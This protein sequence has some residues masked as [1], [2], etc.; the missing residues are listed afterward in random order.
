MKKNNYVIVGAVGAVIIAAIFFFK[1]KAKKAD[2][3]I[4]PPPPKQTIPVFVYPAGIKEG[5]RVVASN[6][7][8]TQFLIK[9]GKKYGLTLAVWKARGYDPYVVIPSKILDL[10]PSGGLLK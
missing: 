9:N 7:D 2:V 4:L 5:M 6:G 8:G 3:P 1:K 10:V